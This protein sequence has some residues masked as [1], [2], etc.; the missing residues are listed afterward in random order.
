MSTETPNGAALGRVAKLVVL[1]GAFVGV[2]LLTGVGM[3]ALVTM[4]ASPDTWARWS[5]AGQA[6]GVLTAVLS[7]LAVAA[8]V[9]T[10]WLQLQELKAQRIELCQ[11]RELLSS[12]QAALTR[13]AEADVRARH[14]SLTRMAIN[15]EDLAE[16]W[17][18]L[19]ADLS[20]RRNR[21]YLYANLILEHAW[22]I[23]RISEYSEEQ[24]RGNLRYLFTSPLM[25]AFW[26]VAQESR[27]TVLIPGTPE[28]LFDKVAREVFRE[29]EL[30]SVHENEERKRRP[31]E[32]EP[33]SRAA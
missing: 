27:S 10:F 26:L 29:N 15:D 1:A 18:M 32:P 6:F 16:V 12:A 20:P 25:R 2:I 30:K 3:V 22:L 13:S 19:Q 7:G 17:P 23:Y 8:L 31:E 5:S 33:E 28:F 11:Q 9:I 21:Q 4:T 24:M 14:E